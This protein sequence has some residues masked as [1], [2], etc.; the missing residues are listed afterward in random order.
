[1]FGALK[2]AKPKIPFAKLPDWFGKVARVKAPPISRVI[3]RSGR[4]ESGPHSPLCGATK[5]K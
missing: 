5:S 1:M 2:L 3:R 4:W